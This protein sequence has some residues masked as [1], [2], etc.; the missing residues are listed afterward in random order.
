[1]R[2]GISASARYAAGSC[3]LLAIIAAF[4]FAQLPYLS[5]EERDEISARYRFTAMPL[6]ELPGTDP[7]RRLRD[8]NPNLQKIASWISS[9]GA[10]VA[11]N[12]LDGDG[13]PNDVCHVDTRNDEITVAPVPGTG[14][15][16][17][18]FALSPAPLPYE[19]ATMAPMGCV[20]A[21]LNED[22][23][24]DLLGYY[25]GR[26]PI[27]YLRLASGGYRPVEIV[28][29]VQRWFT[30]AA[31]VADL[32]GDGHLD[33]LI[34]NYFPDGARILDAHASVPDTMQDS[35]S[36]AYNGGSKRFLLWQQASDGAQPSVTF[37]DVR[38]VMHPDHEGGWT[39]AVG[40][41]DLDGDMLPELYF[42]NDFGPDR[43]LHNRSRPGALTFAALDGR[44]GFT[45]PS[46]KRVGHDSFKG[47]G[48]D[49]ADLNGDGLL[50]IY[51]SNIAARYALLESHFMYV[52]TG[53]PESMATGKA[54]YVDRSES[55]GLSRSDWSWDSRF[56]DF[57]N[58]GVVEALQATGFVKGEVDRWPELQELA[59]G[60]DQMVKHAGAWLR[61]Q[62]GDDIA[63]HTAN[64]F[65][66]KASDGRYYDLAAALD[67][68]ELQVTRGIATADVDGDGDLDFAVANQWEASRFYR[69]DCPSCAPA[70]SLYLLLPTATAASAAFAVQPGYPQML[71]RAAIGASVELNLPDGRRY[72][73]QV[74]GG[75]GH[76]GKRS[77]ELH[78][79]LAGVPAQAALPV[80]IRWR[81]AGGVVRERTVKL[82]AG[83]HTVMLGHDRQGA[84]E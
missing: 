22:G 34:T 21:D 44:R 49:F 2:S 15:R 24:V 57:N 39:L 79:G 52:S 17:A 73:A 64:A 36:R 54:P 76:S 60:N 58:D 37:A 8:V 63:G 14:E 65:F 41:A 69:N 9:V 31:T 1:M 30:N 38:D 77:H 16:Y 43:L 56:G 12:D 78:F 70:L 18:P 28:D 55:L 5:D 23:R 82:P 67:I 19:R 40:A 72:V 6:A 47:M 81:D 26:T 33:V 84:A 20:P 53:D 50:D 59:L 3:A 80:R 4:Y 32:D 45:T 83:A 29:G 66:V 27:V 46:S 7:Q 25:W 42:A 68:D 62:P 48:V 13:L 10:A 61:S 11:L 35:M 71:G 74:D 75:S 51:V